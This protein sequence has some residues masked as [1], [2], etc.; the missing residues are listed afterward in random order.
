LYREASS[1]QAF[2]HEAAWTN[3]EGS[4]ASSSYATLTWALS[5]SRRTWP[6]TTGRNEAK[7]ESPSRK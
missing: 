7:R 2:I 3:V 4:A 6:L 1:A 5:G